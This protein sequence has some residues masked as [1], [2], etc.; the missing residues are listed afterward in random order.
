MNYTNL[1]QPIRSNYDNGMTIAFQNQYYVQEKMNSS[2]RFVNKQMKN[3]I[4]QRGFVLLAEFQKQ[5]DE[6]LVNRFTL[7]PNTHRY[8]LL[9]SMTAIVQKEFGANISVC[10]Y[11]K[12]SPTSATVPLPHFKLLTQSLYGA[13][14]FCRSDITQYASKRDALC[15]R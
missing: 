2:G 8:V 12:T 15:S 13:E 10:L 7:H 6:D 9:E 11:P 3:H 14:A 4:L 5:V 1:L